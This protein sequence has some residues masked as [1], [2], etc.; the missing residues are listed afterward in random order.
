[1]SQPANAHPWWSGEHHLAGTTRVLL[2]FVIGVIF[3]LLPMY[4][5]FSYMGWETVLRGGFPDSASALPVD[6]ARVGGEP[7]ASNGSKPFASRMT[8]ELSQLPQERA[9]PPKPLPTPVP[10]AV[11]PAPPARPPAAPPVTAPAP[12]PAPERVAN[13]RPISAVPPDAR[14]RTREIEKEAQNA[15][16]REPARPAKAVLAPPVGKV[17]E[18]REVELKPRP[19]ETS[20]RP[21]VAGASVDTRAEIEAERSRRPAEIPA[22]RAA[23]AKDAGRKAAEPP[24]GSAPGPQVAGVTP[25]TRPPETAVR[26]NAGAAAKPDG[27][28]SKAPAP[29]AS[30]DVQSRLDTTRE[31]IA[32]AP[33]TT[34]TI[35]L[36]GTNSEEQLKG[37]LEALSKV[38]DPGKLYI[39]RTLAQGKPSITVAYGAYA[40]RQ[41]ALQALEKLPAAITANGPV[42]RTVNGIR[43]EMKQHKTAGDEVKK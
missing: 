2:G 22:P 27:A 40:D 1:M 23:P 6:D 17:I 38:L 41:S 43:T 13:A 33:S 18:G 5:F 19:P 35:Q 36:L 25:I 10:I 11:A 37:R 4:Y 8:Y 31:W 24:A 30:A 20:T 39:F 21:I 14:D 28:G 3:A 15:E 42:L 34:H 12:E 16:Y 9:P 29:S 7:T 26:S 32:A